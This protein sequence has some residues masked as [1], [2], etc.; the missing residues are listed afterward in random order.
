MWLVCGAETFASSNRM[1]N[2][3]NEMRALR[4]KRWKFINIVRRRINGIIGGTAAIPKMVSTNKSPQWNNFERQLNSHKYHAAPASTPSIADSALSG[5]IFK[6]SNDNRQGTCRK[7]YI[8]SGA[9]WEIHVRKYTPESKSIT[10]SII[11]SVAG[12]Q[13]SMAIHEKWHDTRIEA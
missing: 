1:R 3:H 4:E 5:S 7:F 8:I 6:S 12:F 10:S 9:S 2:N 13:N 11:D